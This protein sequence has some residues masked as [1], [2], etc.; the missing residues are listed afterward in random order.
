[1]QKLG[2]IALSFLTSKVDYADVRA[3][4]KEDQH[5]QVKNGRF[6]CTTHGERGIGIRV[7]DKGAW[8][9][10]ATSSLDKHS[11]L[12]C[13]K[14]AI[15]VA[16]ASRRL[17]GGV[18]LSKEEVQRGSYVTPHAIHP[19]KVPRSQKEK[20]LVQVAQKLKGKDIQSLCFLKFT[21]THKLF[22]STQRA[23]TEQTLLE[24][25]G[26]IEVI[27]R[28]GGEVQRRSF[29]NAL[30]GNLL[31]AGYEVV[32]ELKL[33]ENA[34]RVVEEA[35]ALTRAKSC[36][37][38]VFD[39]I[40]M[41]PQLTLQVHESCGHAV[42]LDRVFGMETSFAGETFLTP[43]KLGKFRYGSKQVHITADT[44]LKRGLGTFLFDDEGVK[45]KR[46]PLV[47][48]GIFTGYLSSRETAAKL[49]GRSSGAMRAESYAHLPLIRMVNVYLEPG[50][51]DFDALLADTD[52][53]LLLDINKSW[54]I[55]SRRLQFQ[56]GCEAA[57]EIRKGKLHR[58][59]KNPVY[60]GV[61]PVFWRSLDAVCSE[62][63]F[64]VLGL[65]N[66][67]KG[68]PGQ[69]MHVGHGAAPARFRKVQVGRC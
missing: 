23:H 58:L 38:G 30:G 42:E 43:E 47:R 13:A 5:L 53:G 49:G 10:A 22:W 9:F 34:E 24:S 19:F 57:W 66:C 7:L 54:S 61:T 69:S 20:F 67:G 48:E 18:K 60:A 44:E 1:M 33:L 37:E 2:E 35:R 63:Y 50:E 25:G 8:G 45:G 4:E 40:L 28:R 14:R 29:P 6:S 17:G 15:E 36:P 64:Q 62:K 51:W 12:Q 68:I 11:V 16:Q 21:S 59:Y 32:S 39:L 27:A 52:K 55:D 46:V 56:F 31:A 3:V 65:G 41:P 26:G